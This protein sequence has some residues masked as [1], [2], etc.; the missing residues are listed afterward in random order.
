MRGEL[1]M[2]W[3]TPAG[4]LMTRT[5]SEQSPQRLAER[6]DSAPW[7]V[8]SAWDNGAAYVFTSM[9]GAI[10][11]YKVGTGTHEPVEIPGAIL[12][13]GAAAASLAN[14]RL[15][16][17]HDGPDGLYVRLFDPNLF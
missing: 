2:A 8:A 7:A 17:A 13:A 12:R 16:L 5:L 6:V 15:L 3:R 1:L 9:R 14:E 10:R 4:G 11:Y